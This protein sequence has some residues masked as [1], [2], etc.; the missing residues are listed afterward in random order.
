M[1]TSS[2]T[3]IILLTHFRYHVF[4]RSEYIVTTPKTFEFQ[5][6]SLIHRIDEDLDSVRFWY[7]SNLLMEYIFMC[8]T[9]TKRNLLRLPRIPRSRIIT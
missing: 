4:V 2:N 7:E 9:R 5:L 6:V 3:N 8:L 1:Y